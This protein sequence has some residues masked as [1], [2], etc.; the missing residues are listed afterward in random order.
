MPH[1]ETLLL[2]SSPPPLEEMLTHRC[3][4]NYQGIKLLCDFR[5]PV[6]F[7]L[8]WLRCAG[9]G[10]WSW[11]TPQYCNLRPFGR[12]L[13]ALGVAEA[14]VHSLPKPMLRFP[15]FCH[16]CKDS[17]ANTNKVCSPGLANSIGI[18]PYLGMANLF[19]PL[20]STSPPRRHGQKRDKQFFWPFA[21]STA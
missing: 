9:W 17:E 10:G 16:S 1:T 19:Q 11:D 6:S 15:S 14:R 8:L 21:D 4:E 20:P 7:H 3:L 2:L 5:L 18:S 13:C 12:V